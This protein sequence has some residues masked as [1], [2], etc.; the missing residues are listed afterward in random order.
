M[1]KALFPPSTSLHTKYLAVGKGEPELQSQV[2]THSGHVTLHESLSGPQ[3]PYS[4]VGGIRSK[5][6]T[7]SP[8]EGP[9]GADSQALLGEFDYWVLGVALGH[10]LEQ[11]L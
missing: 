3:S 1:G 9:L 4:E 11:V 7:F 2:L 10:E 6:L 8:S 5:F